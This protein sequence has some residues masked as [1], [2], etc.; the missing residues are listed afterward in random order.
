MLEIDFAESLF[1]T[2][3]RLLLLLPQP[4]RLD[5]S[6]ST[7]PIVNSLAPAWRTLS[8]KWLRPSISIQLQACYSLAFDVSSRILPSLLKEENLTSEL[9][10]SSR[11]SK[12]IQL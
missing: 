1:I 9:H 8:R 12:L 10:K 4:L 11:K 3:N 6:P 7:S 2:S 5:W